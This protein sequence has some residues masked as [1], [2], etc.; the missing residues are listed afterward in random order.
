VKHEALPE[1]RPLPWHWRL[2]ER[3]FE[4]AYRTELLVADDP[5]CLFAYN[6]YPHQGAA[7]VLQCGAAVR[8]GDTV[9]EIHFRREALA[10]L[11]ATKDPTRMGLD[12]IK[13]GDRDIPRLAEALESDPRLGS[14]CALHALTLFHRGIH[15]YGFEVHPV[16]EW[17][18]AHW[19]TWW[20]R[21]VMARDHALGSA[22]VTAHLD[23]LVT[24]HIWV[25]REEFIR[26]YGAEGTH[27]RKR[28]AKPILFTAEKA[29]VGEKREESFRQD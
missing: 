26:R 11:I 17:H 9:L 6:L 15:R 19:F 28:S 1:P 21:L 24:K 12:L 27:R 20:H 14:V 18:L 8:P 5:S 25:S 16:K 29:E 4:H 23:T 10:P 22:R 7:V 2:L 13:L 3:W